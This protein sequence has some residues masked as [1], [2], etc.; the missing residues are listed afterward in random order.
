[1]TKSARATPLDTIPNRRRVEPTAPPTWIKPQLAKLVENAPDGPDWLHEIKFDGY[2]MHVRLDAGRVQI[3]TRRG[4]DWTEKYPAIAKSISGLLAQNAYLDGELCGV[5]P[6]G[7]TAFNLI[8][9]ATDTGQGSL[10]F[11]LFYLLHVNGEN[12]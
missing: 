9:N 11:F 5:L 3:L 12:L 4:N 2:R 6:D 10:L 8:Q 1:M 7:R